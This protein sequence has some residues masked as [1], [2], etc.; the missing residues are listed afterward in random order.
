MA[1]DVRT[2]SQVG[3]GGLRTGTE[4]TEKSKEVTGAR[5]GESVVLDKDSTTLSLELSDWAGD[6]LGDELEAEL[7]KEERKIEQE[8][9]AIKAELSTEVGDAPEELE[10][11][12][13]RKDDIE[14]LARE[15]EQQGMQTPEEILQ[16]LQEN[17]GEH[18]GERGPNDDPTQQYG[19]L[20]MMEKMFLGEGNE[21]M[22]KAVGAAA[23]KLLS[24]HGTEI[25]KGMIVTEAAALYTSEHVGSVS[26]LR[27]LYMEQV[28][29]HKGITSSFNGI[30]E[31]YGDKGF[32]EAVKF[33]LRAAGDDL[34]T[35]KSNT[36][37]LQ[38]K[39]VLDNLYQLEVLNTMR[40]R[41]DGV[42]EQV[43]KHYPVAPEVNSQ[44]VMRE[45]FDMLEHQVRM[46]ETT[47]SKIARD[48]VPESVEGRIAFLREY[49]SLVS[50]IPI[51]VFDDVDRGS[52]GGLRVRERL[53]DV[54]MEAQDVVD[55]EEQEKLNEQ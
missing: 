9:E 4:Q 23:S 16:H 10:D 46:S 15:M 33:L 12:Q 6:E 7:G 5:Q 17:L 18:E 20:A 11:V 14:A 31:K 28:V 22:A 36:D 37:R 25:H 42:L 2:T 39:E 48:T 47:V 44:K 21:E 53:N 32:V 24:E 3:G 41:T 52:G 40:E 51:K 26:D 38:Q 45:T 43:G 1:L 30:M 13:S 54:I 19:A 55:A 8:E 35:M 49:R 34:G 29:G 27:S 50:M